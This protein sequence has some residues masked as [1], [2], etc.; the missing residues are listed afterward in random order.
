M[1]GVV[2]MFNASVTSINVVINSGGGQF[3]IFGASPSLN[4]HPVPATKQPAFTGK[5]PAPDAFGYG[6][7]ECA[8]TPASS[9]SPNPLTI[10]IPD[11]INPSDSIQLYL[12]YED[13]THVTWIVL[14]NGRA[15]S[16]CLNLSS[17][18]PV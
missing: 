6:A 3:R 17:G 12:F 5:G 8:I 13:D 18:P 7:N 15:V 2:N 16:G 11:T 1:A 10:T 9:G 4:W 14:D